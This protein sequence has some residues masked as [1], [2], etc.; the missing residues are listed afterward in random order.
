MRKEKQRDRKRG[1]ILERE[2][3]MHE[4]EETG[5]KNKENVGEDYREKIERAKRE[6]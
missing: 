3:Y 5:K 1:I 2:K 6:D 4:S